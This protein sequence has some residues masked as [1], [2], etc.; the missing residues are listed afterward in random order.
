MDAGGGSTEISEVRNGHNYQSATTPSG[1][2]RLTELFL[3]GTAVRPRAMRNI[4]RY[5]S[6]SLKNAPWLQKSPGRRTSFFGL[7]GIL[8][9]LVRIDREYQSYPLELMN[10]RI[11]VKAHRRNDFSY[12]EIVGVGMSAENSRSA[13]GPGGYYSRGRHDCRSYP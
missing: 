12:D 9:A 8:Q 10:G 13:S 2:L 7:G 3:S 6:D 5:I 4:H 1:A 11:A